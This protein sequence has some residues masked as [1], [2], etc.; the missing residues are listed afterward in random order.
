MLQA[1]SPEKR[2]QKTMKKK[3]FYSPL[4][5]TPI[6]NFFR[7][8]C[9]VKNYIPIHLYILLYFSKI[10]KAFFDFIYLLILKYGNMHK[11]FDIYHLTIRY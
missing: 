5:L 6:E 9:P 7:A 4:P 3:P 8:D 1:L 2:K 11:S 10:I